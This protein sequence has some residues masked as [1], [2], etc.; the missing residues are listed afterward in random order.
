VF[1]REREAR[2]KEESFLST[3]ARVRTVREQTNPTEFNIF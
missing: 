2:F 3:A 1:T